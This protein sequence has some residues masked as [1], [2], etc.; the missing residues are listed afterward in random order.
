[1]ASSLISSSHHIDFD[2]VFGIDDAGLVQMF[3]SL[4]ATGLKEFLGCPA[5]IYEAALTEF[6][7]NSSVRDGLVVSTIKGKAVEISDEVFAVTFELPTEGLTDFSEVPKDLLFDARSLFSISKEQVSISYLKKEM[8]IEYRLLS[9]IL[10]KTIYV[11]AG[12]F[13][14]VTRE[15]F[16]LMTAIT[17][18]V[19]VNW[20]RL[21]FDVLKEMVTPGSRH[22]KGYAIQISVLLKNIPGLE[23]GESRAFPVPRVLN[24]KMVHR[25]VVINENIGGAEIPDSPMLKKTPAKKAVSQKRPAVDTAMAPVVKK[26]RTTKGKPVAKETVD[27]PVEQPPAAKRKIQKRKRRLVLE[28]DDEINVEEQTAIENLVEQV[29]K[30]VDVPV[31][32]QPEVVPVAE[33]TTDDPDAII[34]HVL[35]QLDSVATTDGEDQ[36]AVTGAEERYWFDLPY[37]DLM[38]RL[39]AERQVVTARDT[40]EDMEQVFTEIDTVERTVGTDTEIGTVSSGAVVGNEQLQLVEEA[41]EEMSG[42]IDVPLPSASMEITKI[43]M[44]K[45]I[46]I[47]GVD[48]RTRYLTSLPQIPVDDKGKEILVEKDPVKEPLTN[49]FILSVLRTCGERPREGAVDQFFHSFSF[50]KLAT[51]NV[52]EMAKKEEQVLYWGETETIRVALNRKMYILLKYREV[53]VRKFLESWKQ[54]FVPSEG[55]SATDLKVI[56]ML[57]DLHLF[58]L[59]ELKEQALAHGLCWEKT[60]CSRI[61]EGRIRDRGAI[62]ARSNSNTK[63]SC[64]IRTM[65]RVDGVWTVE[66]CCDQ[67]VKIPRPIVQNEVHRQCSY[68]DTL[69]TVSEFFKILRKIWADICIEAVSFF[70]SGRLIPVGSINF[71]RS[72]SVDG[73]VYRVSPRQTTV[74]ALRVSQFCTIFI[75]YSLF[76][77]LPTEDI[78][79]FVGSIALERTVLRSV[80]IPTLSADSQHVQLPLSLVFESRIVQIEQSAAFADTDEQMDIDLS[81]DYSLHL[82]DN[83]AAAA[84]ISLPDAPIPDVTEALNQLRA[85]I[86]QISERDDG[87][88][89]KDTLLLHLHDFVRQVTARFDAQDRVL[90]ALG[91]DSNDQRNLMSLDIKSSHKQLSTQ[92]ANTDLDV[93]DVRR[94]VREHYLELNA[95]INS[96]DEQVAATRNDLLEFSAQAQ[97]TL[98]IITDQ[99]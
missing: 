95:K 45:E 72:L 80:Q 64:W 67:W 10:E 62:I 50:K 78:R 37:E 69:P 28:I 14:A 89:H 68:L 29:G 65:I 58:V 7:E 91:K 12:S 52:E 57:S 15:Q 71:C 61:F 43:T 54:N 18:D 66:P 16:M 79:S 34:E 46:K 26:R 40:N 27:A 38:A 82:D 3:E 53:L 59:E 6:F 20:S 74:F 93:V 77:R 63:S 22:A 32:G 85:S 21:L 47:P 19:K 96:L 73:P 9:D 49:S 87:A 76:S 1:M 2:S 86:E 60:C 99:Y 5:V 30:P 25:Y 42:D 75:D 17:F 11:K 39:D 13:D 36:P 8:K 4:I 97:K 88:K 41:A 56:N 81:D 55:S 24:E 92:I 94:V 33:A 44:G 31:A 23:L 83:D 98:N 35:D 51:I 90:G 70:V 84:S 48:E